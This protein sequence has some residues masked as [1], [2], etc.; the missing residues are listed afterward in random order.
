MIAWICAVCTSRSQIDYAEKYS[1]SLFILR[2][3]STPIFYEAYEYFAVREFLS[4]S[5]TNPCIRVLNDT[6]VAGV[7]AEFGELERLVK[8][9]NQYSLMN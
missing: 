1:A 9:P 8:K 7:S 5:D 6:H 3:D 4:L 2:S